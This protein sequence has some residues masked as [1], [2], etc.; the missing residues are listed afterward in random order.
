MKEAMTDVLNFQWAP[1]NSMTI[2]M[3]ILLHIASVI[4]GKVFADVKDFRLFLK[5]RMGQAIPRSAKEVV[6]N[7]SD[8]SIDLIVKLLD[9]SDRV[10][11]DIGTK[12]A[13]GY[14]SLAYY[15]KILV[16]DINV[17]RDSNLRVEMMSTVFETAKRD[18]NPSADLAII[19]LNESES[20]LSRRPLALIGYKPLISKMASRRSLSSG[21]GM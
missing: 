5:A 17:R 1:S 20:R 14:P 13:A 2:A 11:L 19:L 8:S 12:E 16:D 18:A 6:F 4:F 10:M 9:I 3:D 7:T 15:L 21:K